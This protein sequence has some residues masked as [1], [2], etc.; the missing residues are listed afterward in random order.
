MVK[1]RGGERRR[2]AER[3]GEKGREGEE[4]GE[5]WRGD[6][7]DGEKKEDRKFENLLFKD[8]ER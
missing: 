7:S 5:G 6:E 1:R 2:E 4:E 3:S 8:A